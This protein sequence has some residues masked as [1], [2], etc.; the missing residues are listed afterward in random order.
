[1]GKPMILPGLLS[2]RDC[3]LC[4]GRIRVVPGWGSWPANL[5][6]VAQSPGAQEDLQG[7]PLVGK[8]GQYLKEACQIV[9]INLDE[10]AF[11]TNVVLCHPPDNRKTKPTEAK[12]CRRWLDAQIEAVDP[13]VMLLQVLEDVNLLLT[14]A[15]LLD[16]A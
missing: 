10:Q 4:E 2:C 1:M 9:G 8:S 16:G 12:A 15:L 6:I 14:D 7:I 11:K 5:M 13:E 3:S